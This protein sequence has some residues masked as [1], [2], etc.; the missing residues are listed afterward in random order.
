MQKWTEIVTTSEEGVLEWLE[1]L[2]KELL[3][4]VEENK[5]WCAEVFPLENPDTVMCTVLTGK[6]IWQPSPLSLLK[7]VIK[8]FQL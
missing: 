3:N 2:Y 6:F 1:N 5:G 8:L 4:L 7:N